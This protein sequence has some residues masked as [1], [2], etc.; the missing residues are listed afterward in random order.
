MTLRIAEALTV[1]GVYAPGFGRLLHL[2]VVDQNS[3]IVNLPSPVFRDNEFTLTIVYSGRLEP[4][5]LDRE[6]IDLRSQQQEREPLTIPLEP[7][8]IY[9]N[10]SLLVSAV[11]GQRLRARHGCGSRC[12]ADY[13]V[14]ASGTPAGPPTPIDRHG[15]RRSRPRRCSCS[16]TIGRSAISRAS[17]AACHRSSSTKLPIRASAATSAM[18]A[19][20]ADPTAPGAAGPILVAP[21][22]RRAERA[23]RHR[24]DATQRAADRQ[25]Q[26]APG[27]TRAQPRRA[28][29]RDPAVLRVDRRRSAVPELHAR[30]DRKRAARRPQPGVLRRAQSAAADLARRLAQRSGELRE[31]PARSSSRTSSRTSGG[32]RRSAGRTITSSG[33]A[34]ASRSTSPRCTPR[35]RSSANVFPAVLR[36]MRRS[37]ID[38]SPQGP[39]YLGYRL[40]HIRGDGRS[41]ARS[42]TTRRRWCCTCCGAWS[43]TRRSSAACAA[44]TP[45]G[46]SGRR[47][48][49]TSAR[50]WR[51]RPDGT[52]AVLRGV[53]LRRRDPARRLQLSLA[54][55]EL[56]SREVRA[57]RRGRCRCRSR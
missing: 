35:R 15:A 47:A 46:G 13:D 1:R 23:G 31:L 17:S 43:A 44:S 55:R 50:R 41:S 22:R 32:D 16:R 14:V 26:P 33:S 27:R 18:C 2:R 30:A 54:G 52:W 8:Y 25:G 57:A 36:Q 10:N 19:S 12:P 24:D 7:R 51:R 49:T 20:R 3:L 37:G 5:E 48:P 11:D 53:D 9:S 21:R 29:D 45:S 42:S 34:R 40:G 4:S 56:D 28:D 6:A 39:V 38:T